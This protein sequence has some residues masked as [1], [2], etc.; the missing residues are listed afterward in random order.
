MCVR[1]V[2]Q[3]ERHSK[4]KADIQKKKSSVFDEYTFDIIRE[5]GGGLGS[6]KHSLERAWGL[7]K[8]T[9]AS[10]ETCTVSHDVSLGYIEFGDSN[11]LLFY[12]TRLFLE[13]FLCHLPILGK[14]THPFCLNGLISEIKV[15][16]II[17]HP[18]GFMVMS[19]HKNSCR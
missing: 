14:S 10:L 1:K 9:G 18:K 7:S 3:I 19:W 4:K 12:R 11:I 8:E 13:S 5:V 16:K 2:E 6:R 15:I 17:P